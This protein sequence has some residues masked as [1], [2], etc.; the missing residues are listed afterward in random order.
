MQELFDELKNYDGRF[1]RSRYWMYSIG[2][3]IVSRILVELVD[4]I[5]NDLISLLLMIIVVVPTIYFQVCNQIK[6]A[7]DLD[8]AGSFIWLGIIPIVNLYPTIL[9]A[10]FKGTDGLNTYG[11]DPLA[12]YNAEVDYES[13]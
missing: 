5:P 13:N 1:N 8:K 2:I 7:H 9:L 6:R 10:F 11:K 4:L 3:S 12:Q